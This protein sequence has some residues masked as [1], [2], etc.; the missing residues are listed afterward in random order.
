MKVSI[1]IP[2]FNERN[3]IVP[4]L[5]TIE[6]VDLGNMQKEIILIDDCSID[7]TR[8]VLR[9]IEKQTSHTVLYHDVNRGKGS[10]LRTGF[11]RVTGDVVIVQDAD[12]E[13]DPRDYPQLLRPIQSGAAQV[14]YGS[15]ERNEKNVS[16]SGYTFYAGGLFLTWLTNALYGSSLTDES[17]C[18]KVFSAELLRTIPLQCRRFEFCP[19]VTANI[20]RRGIPIVEVPISYVPRSIKD[21]KKIKFRD[22]LHAIWTLVKYRFFR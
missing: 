7:G 19:E 2:C 10:A 13:Y 20:L 21:G 17:T 5:R 8:Q 15:R 3:T 9:E 22:G 16:H 6:Q 18:Y 14:V 4:L 1:V 11:Q 12:L